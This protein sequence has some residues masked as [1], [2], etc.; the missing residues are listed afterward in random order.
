[1][2]KQELLNQMTDEELNALINEL[3]ANTSIFENMGIL[4]LSITRIAREN[5][6]QETIA[7]LT[8]R[9]FDED[10]G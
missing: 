2:N 4:P 1:M 5:E 10:C 6:E 3:D 9:F 8:E 7:K